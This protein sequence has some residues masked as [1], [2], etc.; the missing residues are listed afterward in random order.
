[1]KMLEQRFDLLDVCIFVGMSHNQATT[2]VNDIPDN[3]VI[4]WF[5]R[6]S[7]NEKLYDYLVKIEGSV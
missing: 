7:N 4:E 2:F 3:K 1:M 6:M 5:E